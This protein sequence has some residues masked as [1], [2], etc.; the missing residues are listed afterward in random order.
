MIDIQKLALEAYP[1]K[2]V[3]VGDNPELWDENEQ[4]RECW[5]EGYNKALINVNELQV[6]LMRLNNAKLN[7]MK[8]KKLPIKGYKILN[9]YPVY[10]E[11]VYQGKEPFKVVGIRQNE[12]E[13]EGDF[14]G[15]TH[16][17]CQKDWFKDDKVFIVKE[18]CDKELEP[19]G[20][21]ERNVYCCGGGNVITKHVSYWDAFVSKNKPLPPTPPKDREIHISGESRDKQ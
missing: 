16:N 3:T 21:Q 7:K 15:G 1:E 14:S 20:C 10:I 19:N 18:L 13:L 2:L 5:I 6:K 12:I 4:Y 9:M 11:D 8:Y 17:V